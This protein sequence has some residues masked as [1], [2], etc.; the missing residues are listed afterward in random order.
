MRITTFALGPLATNGYLLDEAGKALFIDPGGDPANVIKTLERE[1]LELL[2]ILNTHFHF[3][4][5][6]GN[7]ML[8]EA[9]G[10]NILANPEDEF[11]LETEV[12]G[13][14]F[15]GFPRVG[16]FSF[17]PIAEGER[18]FLGHRC[19]V[20]ATPGHTPGSL[21]FY[22]PDRKAVFVGDLVFERSIGRTDFPGGDMETLLA[23]ARKKIFSL[24]EDTVIYS[25]HGGATTVGDEKNHNPFFS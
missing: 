1:N 5:I 20:L 25:G 6:F 16:S 21:S 3:D 7:T 15:M 4:H 13:G 12:G 9:T 19:K 11:L 23:S 17:E 10:A 2:H 14:G 24:P 8:A 18:E 22:F